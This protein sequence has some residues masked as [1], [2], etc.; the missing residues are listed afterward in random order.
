MF[1]ADGLWELDLEILDFLAF[2]AEIG[3]TDCSKP[4]KYGTSGLQFIPG[5]L[6]PQWQC[7]T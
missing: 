6:S 2:S 5:S 1:G 7:L 3:L 4:D